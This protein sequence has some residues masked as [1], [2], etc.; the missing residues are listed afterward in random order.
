MSTFS[1]ISDGDEKSLKFWL[2]GFAGENLKQIVNRLF[3]REILNFEK[4]WAESTEFLYT[5][6]HWLPP[7]PPL[8]RYSLL[9]T[10]VSV[11]HLLQSMS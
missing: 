6:L 1:D 2:V 8:P 3:L 4:N 9:T 5:P 11:V 7:I 10:R